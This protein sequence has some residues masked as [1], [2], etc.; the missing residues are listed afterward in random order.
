MDRGRRK[1]WMVEG[2][3]LRGE[4]EKKE[5]QT[6][7]ERWMQ[8]VRRSREESLMIWEAGSGEGVS[9]NRRD[10]QL[11]IINRAE[12]AEAPHSAPLP[13]VEIDTSCPIFALHA[14]KCNQKTMTT[15][16]SPSQLA[17]GN[18]V[19]AAYTISHLYLAH[20]KFFSHKKILAEC[21]LHR[22]LKQNCLCIFDHTSVIWQI[23]KALIPRPRLCIWCQESTAS[24]S[25]KYNK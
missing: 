14:Y 18:D 22:I 8:K 23:N 25:C 15:R 16:I 20:M 13:S 7:M 2:R 9:C 21:A 5:I 17:V 19:L 1:R 24:R 6:G 11:H 3:S 12:R 10:E 4:N